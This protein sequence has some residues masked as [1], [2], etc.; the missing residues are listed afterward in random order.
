MTWIVNFCDNEMGKKYSL[1]GSC[2][3]VGHIFQD[4][5]LQSVICCQVLVE[6]N[7]NINCIIWNLYC[8]Q[9]QNASTLKEFI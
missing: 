9:I 7:R 2:L 6:G 8:Q 5:M 4:I 1:N 3:T